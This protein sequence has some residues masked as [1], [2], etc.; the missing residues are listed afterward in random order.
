[1]Q[2]M[3]HRFVRLGMVLAAL[4]GCSTTFASTGRDPIY[5][6][7]ASWTAAVIER[8][9]DP[10]EIVYPFDVTPE[11]KAWAEAATEHDTGTVSRLNRLQAALF[12]PD[13]FPFNYDQRVTLPAR[14]AFQERRG[15]CLAFTSM[16]VTLARS[17]GLPGFLVMVQRSPTVER[18]EEVVIVN[19]H[20][21]AG[22]SEASRL[23]LFDFYERSEMPY[24]Q[25][26]V[27]DDLA[28]SAL[29]HTN[30]G[31]DAIRDGDVEG[32]QRNFRLATVLAP[33]LAA[34]WIG[35]GVTQFR[36]GHLEAALESYRHA[37]EVEP[38]NPSA[39]TNMAY[40]YRRQ[41]LQAQAEAAL[42]AAGKG[43]SSPFTLIALADIELAQGDVR[44]AKRYLRKARHNYRDEPEVWE[45]MA[46]LETAVGDE[47]AAERYQERAQALRGEAASNG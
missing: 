44:Q 24:I 1:M 10:A 29:F 4:V 42:R 25:T 46:R 15:N 2:D 7:R 23:Y 37:L 39:L 3:T 18:D 43:S 27:V 47:S 26:R 5:F 8:G 11:M 28:A 19:R 36:Q 14:Q 30:F 41:G 9:L 34:P 13:G 20:V 16:F 21:V 17:I 45:A 12:S 31:G 38:G 40:I 32:A 6:G 33:E 35:L 22:Y